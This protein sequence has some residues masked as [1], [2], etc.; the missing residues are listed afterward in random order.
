MFFVIK[1]IRKNI[2]LKGKVLNARILTQLFVVFF[3]AADL[4]LDEYKE[5][6]LTK[7]QKISLEKLYD[8]FHLATAL[9]D[10]PKE[11]MD[12]PRWAKIIE[13][14]QAAR[15]ALRQELPRSIQT[16]HGDL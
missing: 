1:N 3:S 16:Q 11:F 5:F 6:G 13:L 15:D 2:G 7:E 12:Q 4:I 8:T 14:A 10:Y 9:N